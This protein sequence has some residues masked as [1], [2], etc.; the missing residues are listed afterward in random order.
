MCSQTKSNE[1]ESGI[2]E[3]NV[4]QNSHLCLY[5]AILNDRESPNLQLWG[6]KNPN[7]ASQDVGNKCLSKR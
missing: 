7:F 4:S 1:F 2:K 3:N 5:P 6:L